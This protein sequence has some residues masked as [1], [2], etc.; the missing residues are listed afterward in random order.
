M[1]NTSLVLRCL[2]I[3]SP[4]LLAVVAA[5]YAPLENIAFAGINPHPDHF[6]TPNATC[7]DV[8]AQ[9]CAN[10]GWCL[11]TTTTSQFPKC[12]PQNGSYCEESY[13]WGNITCGSGRCIGTGAMC[14]YS[15]NYCI[16]N[17]PGGG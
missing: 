9:V 13:Q 6:C 12:L 10:N 7:G 4:T 14:S 3:F 2:K 5:W 17:N 1:K 11:D 8:M 16:P 15:L